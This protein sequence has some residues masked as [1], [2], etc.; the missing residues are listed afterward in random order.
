MAKLGIAGVLCRRFDSDALV[1]A[2]T[3]FNAKRAE[4]LNQTRHCGGSLRKGHTTKAF[5][6]KLGQLAASGASIPDNGTCT[7]TEISWPA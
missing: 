3:S 5:V 4:L 2:L 7:P 6:D 1:D